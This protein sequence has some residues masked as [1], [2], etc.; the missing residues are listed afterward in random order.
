MQR[1]GDGVVVQ[2]GKSHTQQIAR[3]IRILNGVTCGC[4][5][6]KHLQIISLEYRR[7]VLTA[8]RCNYEL[9]SNKQLETHSVPI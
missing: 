9:C 6:R 2:Q 5:V 7:R 4:L 3:K 1:Q 8:R